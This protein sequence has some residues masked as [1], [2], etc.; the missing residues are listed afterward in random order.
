MNKATNGLSDSLSS[1]ILNQTDPDIVRDGAPSFLIMLDSFVEGSPENAGMLGA[2]S[3][4]YAAYGIVF[5]DDPDRAKRLTIRSRDYGRR[6]LCTVNHKTCD[7]WDLRFAD[8]ANA[9]KNTKE[10]D[11]GALFS[12]GLSWMAFIQAHR[13]DWGALA[14]LP[15]AEAI[16][17]RVRELDGTF[18]SAEVEHYLGVMNTLRPPALGGKFDKGRAHFENA[19][20]LSGGTN[21]AVKVDFAKYYARTLYERELHDRLLNEVLE[22]DP[23]HDG[24]T[25]FNTLAQR[26]AKELLGSGD[27]YF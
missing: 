5:V 13:E 25:L 23:V 3:E 16:L 9:I 2:A 27:D 19:I 24:L 8:Y 26:A 10:D 22:A 11:V 17:M 12:A 6:A 20:A 14:K 7:I 18:K 1:A 21:L 4:L 15:N